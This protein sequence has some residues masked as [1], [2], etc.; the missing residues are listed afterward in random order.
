MLAVKILMHSIRM[1][2]HDLSATVKIS[3]LLYLSIFVISF[4]ITLAV[5]MPEPGPD[6]VPP[7]NAWLWFPATLLLGAIG[8]WIAVSWHRYVLLGE[9]PGSI[10]PQ[11]HGGRILG[12]FVASL[13]IGL[14]SIPVFFAVILVGTVLAA[15]QIT[16][17]AMLVPLL[18]LIV[19][20]I[21]F[22]RLAPLLP[23]AAIGQR[24][25]IGEAWAATD[26]STGTMILLA[27]ITTIG[28]IVID[29]PI[30]ILVHLPEG[31]LWVTIWLLMTGWVKVMV[32]ASVLTTIYGYYVEKR[33][34]D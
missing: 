3:G 1:V 15:T 11:F 10:V 32:G 8:L 27:I 16:L 26:G 14:V 12:Y 5:P 29:L 13:I 6:M 20:A 25:S 31:W 2:L 30:N 24:P 34:I 28:A 33:T 22:Y 9:A 17:L 19:I 7:A 18:G 23:G 4:L 21:I